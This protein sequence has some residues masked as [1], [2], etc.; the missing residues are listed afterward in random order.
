MVDI[1]PAGLAMVVSAGRADVPDVHL[2][3]QGG[4]PEVGGTAGE[5]W[6]VKSLAVIGRIHTVHFVHIVR[7]VHISH[8]HLTRGRLNQVE[9]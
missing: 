4:A 1:A 2:Q 8:I 6:V 5:E 9:M 7:I 3:L